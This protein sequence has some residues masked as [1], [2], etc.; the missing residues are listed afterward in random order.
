MCY[1]SLC[2]ITLPAFIGNNKYRRK[3]CLA[4]LLLRSFAREAD[5]KYKRFLFNNSFK[6]AENLAKLQHA[7][8]KRYG[9]VSSSIMS[10]RHV[11]NHN[12]QG[13]SAKEC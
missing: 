10:H 8:R 12:F 13:P 9:I 3:L 6:L 2:F 1:Y 11:T 4:T 7:N 5:A